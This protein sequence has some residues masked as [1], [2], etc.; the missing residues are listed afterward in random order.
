MLTAATV[1]N[2]VT[3]GRIAGSSTNTRAMGS[4]KR[5][6]PTAMRA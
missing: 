5:R 3:S 4:T 2:V 1:R 6:T